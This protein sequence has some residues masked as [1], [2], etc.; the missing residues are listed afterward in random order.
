[1]VIEAARA[2]INLALHVTGQRADGYH[3]LDSLVTFTDFGDELAIRPSAQDRFEIVGRFAETLPAD[4][5]NLVTRA[6]DGL[7]ALAAELGCETCP[8]DITL[9]KSLPLSSGIGGGSADA[10]ATLRG[11]ARLWNLDLPREPLARLCLSLGADVPMC[12]ESSPL[13]AR[14]IG[15]DIEPLA[16]LP[17]FFI[18]LVNPLKPVSTPQIFRSLTSKA[19]APLPPFDPAQSDWLD[20][21]SGLRNDL[22][23]PAQRLLPD[24][25]ECLQQ[26][27]DSG[28]DVCRMSGSGAT[29]FGLYRDEMALERAALTLEQARPQWY[30][31]AGRTLEG[32]AT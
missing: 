30:V 14:G 28:A 22:Q 6:R 24:I 10:A 27:E 25:A 15:E 8:V 31:R 9:T 32:N 12:L 4:A 13:I 29:C 16:T 2:K 5:D 11:L 17:S 7:R 26:L 23:E 3:L 18:L 21:L 1:M 19:N 20:Y